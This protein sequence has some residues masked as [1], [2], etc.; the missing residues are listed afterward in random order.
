MMA[1]AECM[2]DALNESIP[3]QL[4]NGDIAFDNSGNL[5]FATAAFSKV[6]GIPRYTDARLFKIN[7]IDV[8]S[9]PGTATIPMSFVADY[10][11]LDSTVIN[12]IAF[13]PL[14]AMYM[15]TRRF[16]GVQTSPVVT[17]F[18]NERVMSGRYP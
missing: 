7:A 2:Y 3:K 1:L 6:N 10:N 13:S 11:T 4:F 9:T 15:T 17:P 5:F 12:G 16:S 14:G 8:P 18:V